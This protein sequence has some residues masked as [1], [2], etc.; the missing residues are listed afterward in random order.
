MKKIIICLL[1]AVMVVSFVACSSEPESYEATENKIEFEVEDAPDI[2]KE[3]SDNSEDEKELDSKQS[4]V[5]D[6]VE[7][8]LDIPE[9]TLGDLVEDY[10]PS[11]IDPIKIEIPEIEFEVEN[12]EADIQDNISED[13]Q[14]ALNS[15]SVEEKVEINNTKA[16]LLE[17]LIAAFKQAGLN[18]S[19]NSKSGTVSLDS[20]V[21]FGGDSAELSDEGKDFLKKF[22][23]TYSS[24]VYSETYE[25]FI[26]TIMV[27]GHTAPVSGSTYENGLPLSEKRAE[28]V[29]DYC[30]SDDA[31]LGLEEKEELV[32]DLI[33][34]GLSNSR[35]VT[36]ADGN[37]DIAASRRVTFRFLI[38][39]D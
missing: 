31:Q 36:D 34:K 32:D 22:I 30:L 7:S 33:A 20:S 10:K 29:R 6:L 9:V 23:N 16:S 2:S 39:M 12:F 1:V 24:V 4:E 28:V 3:S 26:S 21:L 18:V 8:A 13:L 11:E 27:E 25:D 5:R 17:D 38:D 19:I 37:V 14:S 35:P 15:L